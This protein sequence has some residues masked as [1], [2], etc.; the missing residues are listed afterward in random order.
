MV[1]G[2]F[3]LSEGYCIDGSRKFA[4]DLVRKGTAHPFGVSPGEQ[5]D[6][7]CAWDR[8]FRWYRRQEVLDRCSF[9][10]FY[11]EMPP[12]D[13]KFFPPP[14][15]EV[16]AI[17]TVVRPP[18]R[19]HVDRLRCRVTEANGMWCRDEGYLLRVQ[20][21]ANPGAHTRDVHEKDIEG[22]VLFPTAA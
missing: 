4:I 19:P 2:E 20:E 22:H 8:A 6:L 3:R 17:V 5:Q 1:V 10:F 21:E 12:D 16:G 14:R 9:F 11:E 15:Y 18:W 13:R 7:L